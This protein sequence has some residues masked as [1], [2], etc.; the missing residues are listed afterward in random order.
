MFAY[1]FA[2]GARLG[3]LPSS[4]KKE[5]E[6]ILEGIKKLYLFKD[7]RGEYHLDGICSVA[8]LGGNPYRDGSFRYYICEPRNLDDFKGVGPFILASLEC[9]R[10]RAAEK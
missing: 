6:T 10:L 7:G 9:E 4:F 8:G 2:K 1:G 3:I 5:A